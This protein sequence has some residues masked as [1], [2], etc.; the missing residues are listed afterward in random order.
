MDLFDFETEDLEEEKKVYSV[1]EITKMIRDALEVKFSSIWVE[2]EISNMR[3]PSSGHIYLTLKDESSQLRAVMF[4]YQNRNLKFQLEDGLQVV[5]FGNISV[6]EPRGEYQII[7]EHMEPKGIGALQ[8]AFEQLKERL[9]KEGLFDKEHKKPIPILPRKIGIITSPT[10]AAIRD[11][12]R[13]MERRFANIHMLIYPVRVQGESSSQEIAMAIE[14]MNSA[15]AADVLIL[16]RGGGSIEDLWSFNEEVVARA[17]FRSRIPIISAV[18]HEIDYTI[19]DFVA[20]LRAPTPSAAAEMVIQSKEELLKRI[21]MNCD[22]LARSVMSYINQ[23]KSSLDSILRRKIFIYPERTI[24][25]Y[26][27]RVDEFNMRLKRDILQSINKTREA[28]NSLKKNILHLTP[29]TKISHIRNTLYTLQ[30]EMTNFMTY[31]MLMKRESFKGIL[32]ALDILSPLSVLARGYSICQKY[33][34]MTL[35]KDASSVSKGD[36]VNVKVSKGEMVCEVNKVLKG[37]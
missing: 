37:A 34:S 6:Y 2:G 26:Q 21:K 20:D 12:L 13:V 8:L 7:I 4:R 27:Q 24:N 23:Q 33:P 1:T 16:A 10:G 3:T 22:L 29:K 17:I 25:Q 28:S 18:G 15:K 32:E 9:S 14:E 36:K 19:S 35:I 31:R 11:I 30:K 5:V